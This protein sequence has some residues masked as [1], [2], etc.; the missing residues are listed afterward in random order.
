MN[1]LFVCKQ[2]HWLRYLDPLYTARAQQFSE[3][4]E[5]VGEFSNITFLVP[6]MF[7]GVPVEMQV[8]LLDRLLIGVAG[9]VR[10][11]SLA[12]DNFCQAVETMRIGGTYFADEIVAIN[13]VFCGIESIERCFYGI[14]FLLFAKDKEENL[15]ILQL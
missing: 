14:R 1:V 7:Q 11:E 6:V 5:G 3:L 12:L 2:V 4:F 10:Q 9:G 8:N 15:V 13:N